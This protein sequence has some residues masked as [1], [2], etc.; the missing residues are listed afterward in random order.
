MAL[1]MGVPSLNLRTPETLTGFFPPSPQP[2]ANKPRA[3]RRKAEPNQRTRIVSDPF[4]S[5][6]V[7]GAGARDA[8]RTTLRFNI[9]G[10]LTVVPATE[11][12]IRPVI[13]P[14][15]EEMDRTI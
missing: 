5:A 6:S 8:S 9:A 4:L 7:C 1:A 15:R 2:P 11:Q 14:L 12:L 13:N 3:V 10:D